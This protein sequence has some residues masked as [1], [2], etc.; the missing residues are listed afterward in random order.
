MCL[1]AARELSAT[2]EQLNA[3]NCDASPRLGIGLRMY[4]LR[5]NTAFDSFNNHC[6]CH[7]REGYDEQT[8]IRGETEVLEGGEV[9]V[10]PIATKAC[11]SFNDIRNELPGGLE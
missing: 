6:K 9:R 10:R 4:K 1:S 5:K 8:H 11:W 7:L 3:D 2:L